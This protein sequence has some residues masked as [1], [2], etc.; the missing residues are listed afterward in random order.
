[1]TNLATKTKTRAAGGPTR[2]RLAMVLVGVLTAMAVLVP[3]ASAR[4][5][6]EAAGAAI[7]H[8]GSA[9][10]STSTGSP[11][12]SSSDD[13]GVAAIGA[14]AVL[15]VFAGRPDARRSAGARRCSPR[16]GGSRLRAELLQPH[17]HPDLCRTERRQQPSRARLA[18]GHRI[19]PN[20]ALQPAG[21]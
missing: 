19:G 20:A 14:G 8:P 5:A 12:A 2:L 21:G 3:T 9:T 13:W 1:M 17:P 11:S 18:P 6:G 4:P 7:A 16:S 10:G 15:V